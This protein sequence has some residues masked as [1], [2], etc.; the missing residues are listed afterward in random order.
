MSIFPSLQHRTHQGVLIALRDIRFL[1]LAYIALG[2][3]FI[4]YNVFVRA[5]NMGI[6]GVWMGFAVFQWARMV[7]FNMRVRS[8][9]DQPLK[10]SN[11]STTQ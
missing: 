2:S 5:N 9:L 7:F 3:S 11:D 6:R 10:L 8:L 1:L 4:R